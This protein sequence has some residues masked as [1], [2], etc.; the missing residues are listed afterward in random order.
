MLIR[1]GE[2]G[3]KPLPGPEP[4]SPEKYTVMGDSYLSDT[5][6]IVKRGDAPA[7]NQS[8][9]GADMVLN[10]QEYAYGLGCKSR[11]VIIYKLDKTAE[12]LHG[13]V[14]L[15]DTS[16]ADESGRF[17]VLV[18]DAFGGRAIFD[19]GKLFKGDETME[20]DIEVKDLDFILLEF[21]GKE[22]FGNWADLRVLG[23]D[24]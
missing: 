2:E 3:S 7:I 20:L 16:S 9:S 13:L 22:V 11:S 17:R 10:G 12:R 21:T 24:A 15:D 5:P 1:V 23:G 8:Y 18:E 6:Y 19:S 14:G 4:L